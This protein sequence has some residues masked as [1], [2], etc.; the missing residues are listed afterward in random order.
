MG[1]HGTLG[2]PGGAT[3]VEEP[4]RILGCTVDQAE[5][6]RVEQLVVGNARRQDDVLQRLDG[7]EQGADLVVVLWVGEHHA[8]P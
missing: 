6:R 2:P 5:R 3:R 1:E 7:T 8:C 4:G